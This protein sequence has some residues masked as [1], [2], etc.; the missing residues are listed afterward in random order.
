MIYQI[1][2]TITSHDSF[3]HEKRKI[4]DIFI[5]YQNKHFLIDED[6][7][8]FTQVNREEDNDKKENNSTKVDIITIEIYSYVLSLTELKEYVE[9]I[10]NTYLSTIKNNRT[11]KRF[12]YFLDQVTYRENESRF[13]C[14]REELFESARSLMESKI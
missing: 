4:S 5:V 10:T 13:N 11:N 12:I 14:W 3:S 1:K 6:I 2:E 7:Y 8:V 9:N